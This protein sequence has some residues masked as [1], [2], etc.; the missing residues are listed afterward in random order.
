MELDYK[1]IDAAFDSWYA[2]RK[3]AEWCNFEQALL[4]SFREGFKSSAQGIAK[5]NTQQGKVEAPLCQCGGDNRGG[6]YCGDCGG[7]KER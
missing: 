6:Y 1:K 3:G 2:L 7:L 4:L 5:T